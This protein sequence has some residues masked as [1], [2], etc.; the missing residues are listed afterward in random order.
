[1]KSIQQIRSANFARAIVERCGN[2]QTTAAELLGYAT[3]S[4]VSRYATGRKKLGDKVARKIEEVLDYP[5]NWMDNVHDRGPVTGQGT[6]DSALDADTRRLLALLKT[7]S[8]ERRVALLRFLQEFTDAL[9]GK[10][11][12]A[13]PRKARQ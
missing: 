5:E 13:R 2:N 4:L 11:S 8:P 10:R 1:M 7:F 9:A 6:L 3:P 12:A